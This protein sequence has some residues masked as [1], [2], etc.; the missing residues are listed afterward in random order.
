M[1]DR[2]RL[3]PDDAFPEDLEAMTDKDL[4][5]LDSQIQRQLDHEITV[6]GDSVRETEFRHYE[7]D[8]EFNERDK[9]GN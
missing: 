8:H 2:L 1:T 6:V 7:L 3:T 4:Q 5:V 9:R